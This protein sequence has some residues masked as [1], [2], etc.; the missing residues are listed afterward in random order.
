[1]TSSIISKN[2]TEP[3]QR[4]L[5]EQWLLN[6][7]KMS[8]DAKHQT[9]GVELAKMMG[10]SITEYHTK[11]IPMKKK[12]KLDLGMSVDGELII[13]TFYDHSQDQFLRLKDV[14]GRIQEDHEMF[15]E[16]VK[17]AL[18]KPIE[19][20]DSRDKIILRKFAQLMDNSNMRENESFK[21]FNAI[22]DGFGKATKKPDIN[23]TVDKQGGREYIKETYKEKIYD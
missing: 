1:M 4:N 3:Q 18:E 8:H 14:Q 6:G 20:F 10:F 9:S 19:D 11:F 12:S 2:M 17:K 7:E 13:E 22:C 15:R 5:I 23:V 16:A 21:A